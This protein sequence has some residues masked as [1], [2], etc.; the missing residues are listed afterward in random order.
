MIF[1]NCLLCVIQLHDELVKQ[2]KFLHCTSQL[3][4]YFIIV[5]EFCILLQ[6]EFE[7]WFSCGPTTLPLKVLKF[8][9]SV[10][11]RWF[12]ST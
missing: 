12:C 2:L 11:T 6:W 5:L 3:G 4:S 8:C 10:L 7:I 1:T 9:N